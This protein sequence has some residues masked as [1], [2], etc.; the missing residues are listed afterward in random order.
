MDNK[1][2]RARDAL[3]LPVPPARVARVERRL[4]NAVGWLHDSMAPPPLLLF[5][6]V[7]AL[8]DTAAIKA[9]I[10]LGLPEQLS[11]GPRS[12]G[13]LA[14]AANADE[15]AV[16]RLLRY[17]VSR[18]VFRRRADGRFANN[19][20]SDCLRAD[21]RYSWRGW[22]E[23]FGSEWN[24]ALW[25][26]MGLRV[27]SGQAPSEAAFGVPFF[28]YINAV[29]PD[30]GAAF[31]AAMAAGARLQVLLLGEVLD[32]SGVQH[33]CDIGGGTGSAVA[34][35]VRLHPHLRGTV[36]DLPALAP[37][38]QQVLRD[39]GVEERAVFVGGDFF[40]EVPGECDRYLLTAIIH[41]WDDESCIKILRTIVHA[42]PPHARI[43]V[44]EQ[45][46][47]PGDGVD[48]AKLADMMML[49]YSDGGRERTQSEYESL[50]SRAGLGITAQTTL[51][52]LFEVFEL[53]PARM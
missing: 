10:D 44:L 45:P 50:F 36:F 51:P 33:L 20:V 35:L 49:V 1:V 26:Q 15:D 5:E 22:A 43:W 47:D 4:R 29:N 32:L 28:D 6:R 30:A 34:H 17:L 24:A 46:V 18:R 52:S 41:D 40:V 19:A 37:Q 21:S 38:A 9:A 39:A 48:F 14:T 7:T 3:G 8:V 12:V 11:N 25:N 23:F 16:A 42:M 31:N 27:Q 53:A 13:E 2:A